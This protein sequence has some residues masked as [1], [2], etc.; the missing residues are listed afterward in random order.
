MDQH[1]NLFL[2]PNDTANPERQS[3]LEQALADQDWGR[4]PGVA[5]GW[6]KPWPDWKPTEVL[7]AIRAELMVATVLARIPSL[8]ARVVVNG[9]THDLQICHSL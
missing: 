9:Q 7:N 8:P 6:R 3:V 5:G 4:R 1:V 2:P